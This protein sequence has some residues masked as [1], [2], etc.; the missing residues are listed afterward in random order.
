MKFKKYKIIFFDPTGNSGWMTE[1]ELYNF[2]PEECIIEAYVY[3]KDRQFVH[4]FASYTTNKD[5]GDT[6]YGDCNVLPTTCVK[7]MKRIYEKHK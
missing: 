4:T 3:S 6:D 2:E 7:S 1:D 5:T